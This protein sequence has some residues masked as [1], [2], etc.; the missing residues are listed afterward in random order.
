MIC[1]P[2]L[3]LRYNSI[4][5]NTK[6]YLSF[7]SALLLSALIANCLIDEK[8]QA[9]I[10]PSFELEVCVDRAELIAVGE[11]D[12]EN[13]FTITQVLNTVRWTLNRSSSKARTITIFS[14]E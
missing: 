12:A 4:M 1:V 8:A 7:L 13:V 3:F 9:E 11:L 2:P 10:Q 5:S 14:A 6:N